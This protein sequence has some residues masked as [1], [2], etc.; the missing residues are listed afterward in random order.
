MKF[1]ITKASDDKY[2][3][4]REIN[5]IEDMKELL[6]EHP[7]WH[8]EGCPRKFIVSFEEDGNPAQIMIYDDWVE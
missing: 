3:A 4:E 2:R 7:G 6:K 5:T 8:D 1:V